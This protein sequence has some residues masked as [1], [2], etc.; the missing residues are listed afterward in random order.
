MKFSYQLIFL[1]VWP[2]GFGIFGCVFRV[3][4]ELVRCALFI[5]LGFDIGFFGLE[6]FKLAGWLAM[7]SIPIFTG[8]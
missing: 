8:G 2:G 1:L 5:L 7:S 6:F 3:R 4:P